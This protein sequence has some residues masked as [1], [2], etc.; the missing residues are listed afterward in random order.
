MGR[1][2]ANKKQKQNVAIFQN[3]TKFFGFSVVITR[4]KFYFF[5]SILFYACGFESKPKAPLLSDI[6]RRP[7]CHGDRAF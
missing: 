4:A 7:Y 6:I 3:N 5:F 1:T 2:L